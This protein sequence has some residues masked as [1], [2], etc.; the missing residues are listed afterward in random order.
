MG[1]KVFLTNNSVTD[2]N[3]NR[4]GYYVA[5]EFEIRYK[6]WYLQMNIIN[7]ANLLILYIFIGRCPI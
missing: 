5:L 7:V 1:F 6:Y 2:K 4:S 3:I